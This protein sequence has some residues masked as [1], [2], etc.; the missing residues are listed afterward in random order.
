MINDGSHACLAGF[1]SLTFASDRSTTM[2][3]YFEESGTLRWTS[4]ELLDPKSFGL[5]ETRPTKE[6]DCYALGMVIYEVL[7]GQVPFAPWKDII[8]I[9]KIVNGDRPERPWGKEGRLIKGA[10]WRVLEHC[11]K[12]QPSE[13]PTAKAVLQSLESIPSPTPQHNALR[14]P[15]PSTF[16]LSHFEHRARMQSSWYIRSADSDYG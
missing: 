11:W 2:M 16:F 9:W 4:P 15:V 12:Y 14:N 7:S 10:I 6:S 1:S 13:R 8:V 5:M 3:S